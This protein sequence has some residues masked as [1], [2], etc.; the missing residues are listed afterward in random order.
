LSLVGYFISAVKNNK[1]KLAKWILMA[2]FFSWVGDVLL[3]FQE[4]K[5]DLFL[6]GLVSFLIAHIFYIIF[7]NRIRVREKI[8]PHLF[9]LL[10][11]GIYYAA[12]II[13]LSP[14]LD[15]MKWPVR[16]YGFVI[17]IMLMLALHMLFSRN[18]K[19]AKWM[20]LGAVLF[21]I[22]DSVLAINKFYQSF[23]VADIIIMLSYGLAQLFIVYG[24]VRYV[25]SANSN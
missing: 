3:M 22:S 9:F 8:K 13:R 11:V 15:A 12:L 24:A 1:T 6:F 16:V 19:A 4:K 18:K 14:F 7:F 23:E 2:L 21:V 25:D 10:I 5:P 17:S 20:V